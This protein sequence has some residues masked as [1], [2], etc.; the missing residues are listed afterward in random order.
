MHYTYDYLKADTL[1]RLLF[2]MN[3]NGQRG[4][5][6]VG[7]IV[8]HSLYDEETDGFVDEYSCLMERA[9]EFTVTEIERRKREPNRRVH[10]GLLWPEWEEQ[11][12]RKEQKRIRQI[13]NIDDAV[14]R[15]MVHEMLH[16]QRREII[17][18]FERIKPS[19]IKLINK[20]LS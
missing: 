16:K 6:L 20:L 5:K 19:Y 11:R 2:L 7:K 17:E 13:K 3:A 12:D 1:D 18:E 4:Y 14:S 10:D 15:M 8:Y 9:S